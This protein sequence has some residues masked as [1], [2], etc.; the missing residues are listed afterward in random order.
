MYIGLKNIQHL[1]SN[2]P[3]L[4]TN[5]DGI[6]CLTGWTKLASAVQ[7][8]TNHLLYTCSYTR[9]FNPAE[10]PFTEET[11]LLCIVKPGTDLTEISGKISGF[12]ESSCSGS[13]LPGK[14]LYGAS[15][16]F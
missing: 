14:Y 8:Y 2:F 16:L 13:S 3:N 15:E 9:N 7:P 10:F 11:H 5:S 1:F 4:L 6:H 12:S